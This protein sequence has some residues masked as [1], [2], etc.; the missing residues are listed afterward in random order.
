[1]QREPDTLPRIIRADLTR[2]TRHQD[3]QAQILGGRE[4][5]RDRRL[6]ARSKDGTHNDD[7]MVMSHQV[8]NEYRS[9]L[10]LAPSLR[11]HHQR[12][13]HHN[14]RTLQRLSHKA[15]DSKRTTT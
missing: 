5:S 13:I 3:R 2:G 10:S 15:P 11:Q 7:R 14:G 1:M 4:G 12:G 8:Y 9:V 6:C